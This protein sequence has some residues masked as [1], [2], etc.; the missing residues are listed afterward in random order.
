MEDLAMHQP[1]VRASREVAARPVRGARPRSADWQRAVRAEC[2]HTRYT[3]GCDVCA[4]AGIYQDHLNR[5]GITPAERSEVMRLY[6]AGDKA[7][8]FKLWHAV[9]QSGGS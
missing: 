8:L 9:Q 2:G 1:L 5:P 4:L 3:K 6:R 7:G